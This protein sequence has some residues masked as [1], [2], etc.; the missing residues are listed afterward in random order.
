[1]KLYDSLNPRKAKAF[2]RARASLDDWRWAMSL[3]PGDTING[4]YT[5]PFN[6]VVDRI[7]VRRINPWKGGG[8]WPFNGRL[9]STNPES[10]LRGRPNFPSFGNSWIV[11]SVGIY[12]TDGYYHNFPGGGCVERPLSIDEIRKR[13]T[14]DCNGKP[15]DPVGY[16]AQLTG[17]YTKWP[18]DGVSVEE[19]VS[20]D[21]DLYK[22]A[23][24]GDR[25]CDD[26]GIRA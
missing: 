22:K 2:L 18:K 19:L 8:Y 26:R 3:K 17:F 23:H 4:C 20:A 14:C 12:T 13:L 6:S 16:E 7:K 21:M 15:I 1:M 5:H 11:E 10:D 9:C 24:N 25:I